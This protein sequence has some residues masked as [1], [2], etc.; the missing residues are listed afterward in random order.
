MPV[1]IQVE[2]GSLT[3]CDACSTQLSQECSRIGHRKGDIWNTS[4]PDP[5]KNAEA[6]TQFAR[7]YWYLCG[8]CHKGCS[9]SCKRSCLYDCTKGTRFKQVAKQYFS[10]PLTIKSDLLSCNRLPK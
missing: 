2:E 1:R 6:P 10:V 5:R 4:Q 8:S 9:I 7:V 3:L